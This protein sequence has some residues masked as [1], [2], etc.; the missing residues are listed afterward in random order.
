MLYSLIEWLL[1]R[2]NCCDCIEDDELRDV[3]DRD[4]SVLGYPRGYCFIPE[5][6]ELI[7][8]RTWSRVSSCIT[9]LFTSDK[10]E[11]RSFLC[12]TIASPSVIESEFLVLYLPAH[13]SRYDMI[14]LILIYWFVLI[15]YNEL[16]HF[17]ISKSSL[18]WT[19]HNMIINTATL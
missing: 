4:T 14:P 6:T 13:W 15:V 1:S 19:V 17:Y 16:I 3:D 18:L 12:I 8:K 9:F 11:C 7:L 5:D 2:L 10:C